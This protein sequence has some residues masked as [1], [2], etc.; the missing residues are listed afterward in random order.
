[1]NNQSM[2]GILL[3]SDLDGTMVTDRGTVPERNSAAIARFKEAGG[4]FAIA[5]GRSVLGSE[6]YAERLQPNAPCIVFNGGAIYD[7]TQKK[8]LWSKTLPEDYGKIIHV[9]EESF[10]DIGIEI[11]SGGQVYF[12]RKNSYTKEHLA[13]QG[14]EAAGTK[15]QHDLP[16]D[17]NKIL[18][19]GDNDKLRA[20]SE[21]LE[22][23]DHKGCVFVFSNPI[24]FEVLPE[25][26]SKG[27]TVRILAD[28]IGI[29]YDKIMA[30]GDYYNDL[31][32]LA[33]SAVSAVPS[34][35]PEDVKSAAKVVV[36][37]CE[38][39]AVA[40]FVEYIEKNFG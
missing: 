9:V 37:P 34:G 6:R 33:A 11:Y 10:P 18:F 39:G 21:R 26:I 36:G 25:G 20:V 22:A 3:V 30:I 35:A 13:L 7:F 1:M 14:I 17:C 29:G 31:E 40:D 4:S 2:R 38:N 28:L 8:T 23:M 5:T 16:P 15:G 32:L 19:T 12:V 27:T 24:Y